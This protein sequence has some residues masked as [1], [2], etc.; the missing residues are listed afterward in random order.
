M[1]RQRMQTIDDCRKQS[2]FKGDLS[3]GLIEIREPSVILAETNKKQKSYIAI[4]EVTPIQVKLKEYS[5]EEIEKVFEDL[6]K[7]S[8]LPWTQKMETF[9]HYH[10]IK[11]SQDAFDFICNSAIIEQERFGEKSYRLNNQTFKIYEWKDYVNQFG[12]P[13][14]AKKD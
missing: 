14:F 5:E 2:G 9:P 6:K 12:E 11:L 4:T 1:E 10:M 3:S 13:D 8:F 7:Y